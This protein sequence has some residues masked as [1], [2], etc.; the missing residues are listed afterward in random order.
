[1]LVWDAAE[2]LAMGYMNFGGNRIGGTCDEYCSRW[3]RARATRAFACSPSSYPF[4]LDPSPLS[5]CQVSCLEGATCC[6]PKRW[7]S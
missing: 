6:Q 1:M 2:I 5:H 7:I 4:L 3:Q